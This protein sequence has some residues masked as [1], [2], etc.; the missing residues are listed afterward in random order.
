MMLLIGVGPLPAWW[1]SRHHKRYLGQGVCNLERWCERYWVEVNEFE[2]DWE[3][4]LRRYNITFIRLTWWN[5]FK[6]WKMEIYSTETLGSRVIINR[7]EAATRMWLKVKDPKK[8]EPQI[9]TWDLS[10]MSYLSTLQPPPPL[11]NLNSRVSLLKNQ[12]CTHWKGWWWAAG[13]CVGGFGFWKE[14]L[15][16]CACESK[17]WKNK[18]KIKQIASDSGSI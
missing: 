16:E 4:S 2:S 1:R 9:E 10:I 18:N 3:R 13:M 6:L 11:M 14:S 5:S 7:W 15:K 12:D 17:E 8:I